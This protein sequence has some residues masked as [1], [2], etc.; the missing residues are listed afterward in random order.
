MPLQRRM[1][2]GKLYELKH[3]ET[4]KERARILAERYRKQGNLA[5]VR[6]GNVGKKNYYLIYVR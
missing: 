6:K 2:G 1:K 4:N 3:V 5:Q